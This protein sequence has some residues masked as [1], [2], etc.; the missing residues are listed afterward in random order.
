MRSAGFGSAEGSNRSIL[1]F[2]ALVCVSKFVCVVLHWFC[3]CWNMISRE[4]VTLG[5]A[6]MGKTVADLYCLLYPLGAYCLCWSMASVMIFV[7]L[8][9]E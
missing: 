6:Q 9:F 7:V 3:H 1:L 2:I 5:V 4:W 8:A